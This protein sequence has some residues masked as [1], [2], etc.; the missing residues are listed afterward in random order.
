MNAGCWFAIF[1][2]S[3]EWI[4]GCLIFFVFGELVGLIESVNCFPYFGFFLIS[5][6]MVLSENW[7]F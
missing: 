6:R 1:L 3:T 2:L 4:S 5:L 7:I